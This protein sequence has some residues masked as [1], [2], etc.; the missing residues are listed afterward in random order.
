MPISI[1]FEGFPTHP[2]L[3][4]FSSQLFRAIPALKTKKKN[5][6]VVSTPLKN[7]KVSWDDDIPNVWGK[8]KFMF[9]TTNQKRLHVFP[10]SS[11]SPGVLRLQLHRSR[12][13]QV[14]STARRVAGAA[15]AADAEPAV[16][17]S[18]NLW[19]PA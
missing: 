13:G 16:K 12:Q 9:Q 15:G 18:G 17:I 1:Q 14:V 5:W 8:I 11:P 6:F 2:P 4:L 7:M 19:K 10:I 3:V